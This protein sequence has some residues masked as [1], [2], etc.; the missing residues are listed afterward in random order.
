MID[1]E[2]INGLTVAAPYVIALVFGAAAGWLI[3]RM[4]YKKRL[5]AYGK[6]ITDHKK[7]LGSAK[8][9]HDAAK[10]EVRQLRASIAMLKAEVRKRIARQ[11]DWSDVSVFIGAAEKQL[12]DLQRANQILDSTLTSPPD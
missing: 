2:T 5:D 12:E 7:Q 6:R 11:Q 1:P 3:A 10:A 8:E 9:R 4:F